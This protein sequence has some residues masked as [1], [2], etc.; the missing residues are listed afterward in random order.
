MFECGN[1]WVIKVQPN[2]KGQYKYCLCYVID[3]ELHLICIC[4]QRMK[5]V[6][7]GIYHHHIIKKALRNRAKELFEK[8]RIREGY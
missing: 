4:R 8:D 2:D 3:N 5:D 7:Q 6:K 1:W